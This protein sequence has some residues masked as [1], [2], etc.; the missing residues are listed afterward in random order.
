MTTWQD[1]VGLPDGT[2]IFNHGYDQCVAVANHYHENVLGGRFVPVASAWQWWDNRYPETEGIYTRSQTPVAGAIFVARY[3]IYN[4]PDGHI[5]VVT[6]VHPDGTFSTLEQ[7]AEKNRYLA[8]YRRGMTNV[9]GFLIPKSNPVG[10][11]AAGSKEGDD[12]MSQEQVDDIKKYIDARTRS[13]AGS[14]FQIVKSGKNHWLQ[15]PMGRVGIWGADLPAIRSVI[16]ALNW[17]R[18]D[19]A[20]P[21]GKSDVAYATGGPGPTA[22]ATF[23]RYV[24]AAA[25]GEKIGSPITKKK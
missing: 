22:Y 4:A 10:G 25:A 23:D 2:R 3:G 6:A 5:G 7:N 20:G 19:G 13:A 12:D 8:R 16:V 14:P 15:T 17:Q 11:A 1:L 18:R 21:K 24:R 9:L